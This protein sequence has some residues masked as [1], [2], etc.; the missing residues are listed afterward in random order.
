MDQPVDGPL[1]VVAARTDRVAQST[2]GVALLAA[3]VFRVP[4][5]V[6]GLAIV[7]AVGALAG[8]SAN[9]F[10]LVYERAIAPRLPG[11]APAADGLDGEA[12]ITASTVRA[13]D[14]LAAVILTVASLAF[15]LG[16][17]LVGWL[18]TLGAAVSAIVA[19]TTRVHLGDR[20]RRA[21]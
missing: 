11:P 16:I 9:L 6:P 20:V 18:L 12:P 17:A 14:A 1:D 21:R 7:L 13:Q 2:V 19:A 3:F 4:W 15:A 8:P 10:H 5:L